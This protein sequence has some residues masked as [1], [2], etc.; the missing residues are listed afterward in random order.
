M[1]S[2]SAFILQ[3]FERYSKLNARNTNIVDILDIV[4]FRVYETTEGDNEVIFKGSRNRFHLECDACKKCKYFGQIEKS[5]GLKKDAF[6]PKGILDAWMRNQISLRHISKDLTVHVFKMKLFL[7]QVSQKALH[8]FV[9]CTIENID[10]KKI[11]LSN[12]FALQWRHR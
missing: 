1:I 7:P 3:E 9:E 11:K 5:F 6:L 8:S 10:N 4:Y 12:T 2:T